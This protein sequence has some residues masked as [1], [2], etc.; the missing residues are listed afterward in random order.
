MAYKI[1]AK[2]RGTND[3]LQNRKN[4]PGEVLGGGILDLAYVDQELGCYI[5]AEQIRASL[6]KAAVNFIHTKSTKKSYKDFINA[7]VEIEPGKIRLGKG[8]CDYIHRE[9]VKRKLKPAL[10]S[11]PA[12][13]KG[14]EVGFNLLVSEDEI[15]QD[16]L[17]EILEHAGKFVGI[18]DWRPHFGRFEIIEFKTV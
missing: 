1:Q 13:R 11:R 17:K 3:Y 4:L 14:W 10:L 8:D 12:F 5:P 7:T 16:C 9:Y 6:V 2:I 18:G 15:S